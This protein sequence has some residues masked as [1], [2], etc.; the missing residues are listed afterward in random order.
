MRAILFV[1]AGRPV[2]SW[3]FFAVVGMWAAFF[4]IQAE[5]RR[6]G[7]SDLRLMALFLSGTV[8]WFL[9]ARLAQGLTVDPSFSINQ[10]SL[11]WRA[12]T[13]YVLYGGVLGVFLVGWVF[14]WFLG[15]KRALSLS[16]F[17]DFGAAALGWALFWGRIGCG[18]YG[19]CYG[20]PAGPW[21]GYELRPEYWDFQNREF[22]W[23][24]QGVRLHPT[25][26]YEALGIFL[27]LVI[28]SRLQRWGRGQVR[29]VP[30]GVSGWLFWFLYGVLRF[31]L[32]WIRLDLR[33]IGFAGL[34][35]SQ[36][37]SIGLMGIAPGLMVFEWYRNQV[38]TEGR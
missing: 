19:C 14:W 34:S 7:I 37:V 31:F 15:L 38:S 35:P 30:P 10:F 4:K 21:P 23:T 11:W 22:P 9:G 29:L 2:I 16:E 13:G 8:A 6:K 24:L 26:F 25:P 28:I 5:L 17:W 1:I 3:A 18:F 33:G 36:W 32:E 27:C 20:T 12:S